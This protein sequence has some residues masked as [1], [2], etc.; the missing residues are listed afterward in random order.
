MPVLNVRRSKWNNKARSA[1]GNQ[2]NIVENGHGH[3]MVWN[4]GSTSARLYPQG[5]EP[6]IYGNFRTYPERSGWQTSQ[7]QDSTI[8]ELIQG[9]TENIG[10]RPGNYKLTSRKNIAKRASTNPEKYNFVRYA[11]T[12]KIP[13][14]ILAARWH[15]LGSWIF[16]ID[17]I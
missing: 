1:S 17:I 2:A 11:E 12:Q 14:H 16:A 13:T 15:A 10:M 7:E 3:P 5:I 9:K 4:S 8:K 6:Y